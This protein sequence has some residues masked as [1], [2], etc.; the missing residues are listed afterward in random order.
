MKRIAILLFAALL[1]AACQPTPEVD[2]VKQKDTNVLIDTVLSE[3]TQTEADNPPA[4]V[5]AQFPERFSAE[6]YTSANNV[7]VTVDAPI[8]VM[9]DGTLP[10]VR[11]ER[12]KLT[13]EQRVAL[14]KRLL[15]ADG[16]YVWS[17]RMTREDLEREIANLLQEPTPEQKAEWLKEDPENTEELWNE[18]MERRKEDLAALQEQYRSLNDG[19]VLPYP[20]WD[21]SFDPD[22][23]HGYRHIVSDPYASGTDQRMSDQVEIGPAR[24]DTPVRFTAANPDEDRNGVYWASF[25]DCKGDGDMGAERIL[26]ERYGEVHE[27]ASISAKEAAEIALSYLD[28]FGTFGVADIYWSNNAPNGGND[29]FIAKTWAYSVH[30][31]PTFCGAGMPYCNW[32]VQENDPVTNVTDMWQY[33]HVSAVVTGDGKL[34]AFDWTGALKETEVLS[35][36]TPLLPF[37]EIQSIFEQ[38][39][40]REFAYEEMRDATLT[41]S[42]V[43]LGLFRIR[44][45]NDME[46]GLLTP[47]WYFRG[48]LFPSDNSAWAGISQRYNNS[49]PLLIINA[50]DGT[51]INAY[52]GY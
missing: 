37:T 26:P 29:A 8:R 9:T 31:T 52:T 45:K 25:F 39:I 11:V 38:Q 24:I 18:N 17:Y 33:S 43:Q 27:G 15:D 20:A 32:F 1:L 44:E 21:G 19:T 41:V 51:I 2:A 30:L 10:L 12:M 36:T 7:H 34:L 42:D 4:P 46:H 50:I 5:K 49:H 23:V 14:A 40:N 6:F 47:V 16:L 48:T 3:Q 28:G 35:E 13:D 22:A